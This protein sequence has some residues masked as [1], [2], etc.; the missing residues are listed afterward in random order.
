MRRS[1]N[2]VYVGDVLPVGGHKWF[3]DAHVRRLLP[4]GVEVILLSPRWDV[5]LGPPFLVSYV[6][7]HRS[8]R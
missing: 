4:G 3:L 8:V 1:L 7:P 2:V 6:P 5:P